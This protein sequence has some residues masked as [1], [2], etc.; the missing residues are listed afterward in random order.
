MKFEITNINKKSSAK[1]G[2]IKTN[3]GQ[4][5]TP[6]FM[7]VATQASVKGISSDILKEIGVNTILC[8]TYHLYQRPGT[9][10]I[11]KFEG[12][13]KFMNWEGHIITDSGGFQVFS[14]TELNKITDEGVIFN[15]H[16]DGSKIEL[17]PKKSIEIQQALNADIMMVFDDCT[18]YPASYDH[19]KLSLDRSI[20]WAKECK[21]HKTSEH[22][23]LFG[24]IQGG[25]Y[26]DL[27]K[28]SVEALLEIGFDGYAIGGL[29]VGEDKS[30]RQEV[31]E[32]L[33]EHLPKDKPI[34]LMGVGT[35]E[36]IIHAVSCG[37]D[38]FDCVIPTRN[39]RNGTLFTSQGRINIKN[40]EF[41]FDKGQL[42]PECNC[43]TCKKYSRAYLRHL[44]R[45]GEILSYV[46]NTIH[47]L[48]FYMRLME[49]I[50]SSIKNY[51]LA[52]VKDLY[53]PCIT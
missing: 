21:K 20:K 23:A 18:P 11:K 35:P 12:L 14:L 6:I 36:D 32:D 53:K 49:E 48:S 5:E 45:S 15:S 1:T 9:S 31:L 39:A 19:T 47:N 3:R 7:P 10:V 51:N 8:N 28:K 27:R 34:Y 26:K 44:Y 17:T 50:Q 29:S 41:E 37:V 24:I 13:H 40:K 52:K 22:Q 42:D 4:I 33:K 16:I 30:L 43:L 25:M 38:M 2:V 46:A